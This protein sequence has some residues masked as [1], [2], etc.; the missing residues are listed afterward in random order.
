MKTARWRAELLRYEA[1]VHELGDP[2]TPAAI[3]AAARRCGFSLPP[4]FREF[5]DTHDG[6]TL[7]HEAYGIGPCADLTADV[8]GWEGDAVLA[9]DPA[10]ADLDG[11]MP[12]VRFEPGAGV[13]LTVGS[14]FDRWLEAVLLREQ[15]VYDTDGDFRDVFEDRSPELCL[16]V[17]R[18]REERSLRADPGA[19][20]PHFELGR[21]HARE[22]RLAQA[23]AC[24]ERAIALE[25][26]FPW[27]HFELG[28][29]RRE[30]GRPAEAIQSFTRAAELDRD[31]APVAYAW[32]ARIAAERGDAQGAA[33]L[34]ARV[35]LADPSFAER[36]KKVG[37]ELLE[38]GDPNA[39]D[40]LTLG[41]AI[42]PDPQTAAL[43]ARLAPK[44]RR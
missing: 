13:S 10:R 38:V 6:G 36:H 12:M 40:I 44:R 41:Q 35:R 17:M 1:G 25:P 34:R 22:G 11:E 19:P 21:L 20:A 33:R 26:D 42:E 9:F 2:A 4:S 3:E 31:Q 5:L 30:I 37:R 14:R 28:R 15:L 23:V 43:L 24:I 7:F 8:L 16:D 29:L 32:A 39:A 18:K 27:A